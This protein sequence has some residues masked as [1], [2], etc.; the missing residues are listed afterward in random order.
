MKNTLVLKLYKNSRG[1]VIGDM[2]LDEVRLLATSH[3]AT[4]AAAIFSMDEYSFVFRSE[5]GEGEFAFPIETA[6]LDPLGSLMLDQDEGN[7]M[8]GFATFSRF[9]FAHPQPFD[10]Q[11]DI[12]FRSAV[13]H[14]RKDLVKIFPSEPAPKGFK[15]ELLRRIRYIYFPFC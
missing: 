2:F 1:A 13:W 11:S 8:S 5:K 3:P 6:E 10:T 4:I 14:I 7:F 15:K 9:D 12:H